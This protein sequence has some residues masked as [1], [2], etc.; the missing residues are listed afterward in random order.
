MNTLQKVGYTAAGLAF[1]AG[2][3]FAAIQPESSAPVSDRLKGQVKPLNESIQDF[4]IYL[5]GFLA[6]VAVCYMIWGGV[7][8]LTA[9]GDDDSVKQGKNVIIRAALGLLVIALSWSFVQLLITF[10][11]TAR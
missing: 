8:I 5:M 4:I 1:T 6:L 3:T 2:Q 10:F 7:K 9:G 11:F